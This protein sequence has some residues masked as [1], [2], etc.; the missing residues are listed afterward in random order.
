MRIN[1]ARQKAAQAWCQESTK[2]L[3]MIPELAE[4]FSEILCEETV[5][6]Q[7][8]QEEPLVRELMFLLNKKSRENHSN[9]PDY[10]LAEFLMSCLVSFEEAIQHRDAWYCTHF[11]PSVVETSKRNEDK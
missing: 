11:E 7:S 8:S 10:I 3:D 5:V 2:H 1:E 6:S 9:T 4:A